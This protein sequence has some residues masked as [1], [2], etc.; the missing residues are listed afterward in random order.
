MESSKRSNT[1]KYILAFV[2][3]VIHFV[4]IYMVLAIAFKSPQDGRSRVMCT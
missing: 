4:P 3:I 2:I 1:W